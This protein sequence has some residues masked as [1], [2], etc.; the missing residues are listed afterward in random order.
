MP[1]RSTDSGEHEIAYRQY[2]RDAVEHGRADIAN[3]LA[4]PHAQVASELRAKYAARLPP[5]R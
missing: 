5:R 2:V 4:I 3:G 1:P